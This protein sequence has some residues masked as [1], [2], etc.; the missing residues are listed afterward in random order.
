MADGFLESFAM[1]LQKNTFNKIILIEDKSLL[2]NGKIYLCKNTTRLNDKLNG[3]SV[4][5]LKANS[6]NPDIN[7]LFSSIIPLA[8]KTEVLCSI[9]TGIGEDGVSSC[10]ELQKNGVRCMTESEES[11]IIDGMPNRA[12]ELV[13]HI[14]VYEMDTIIEKISEFCN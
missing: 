12:R 14:E 1:Q 2:E 6:Y 9:L 4:D 10:K 3:F 13:A 5:I 8:S 11:A 7:S